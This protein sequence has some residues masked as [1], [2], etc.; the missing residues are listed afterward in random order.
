MSDLY[1]VP[2]NR[3]YIKIKEEKLIDKTKFSCWTSLRI[4]GLSAIKMADK[5]PD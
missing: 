2:I 5:L 4:T 1:N 3:F